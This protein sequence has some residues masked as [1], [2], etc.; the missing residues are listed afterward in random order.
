V[1]SAVRSSELATVGRLVHRTRR[2]VGSQID[3]VSGRLLHLA[4]LP[5]ASDVRRLR[6]Q[7]GEMDFE[8]RQLR[9]ELAARDRDRAS[10]EAAGGDEP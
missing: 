7:L 6:R 4:N 3:A 10:R 9:L 2:A 5:T 1:E 8:L